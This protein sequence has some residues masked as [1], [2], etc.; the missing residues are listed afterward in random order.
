MNH[1]LYATITVFLT[2]Q[3]TGNDAL[4]QGPKHL[5]FTFVDHFEPTK[6][7]N[8]EVQPW[9]SDYMA[10]ARKHTDADGKHP[11][12][13][14]FLLACPRCLTGAREKHMIPD[15]LRM[16]NTV[17]YGGFGEVDYHLHHGEMDERNRTEEEAEADLHYLNDLTEDIF[18]R[19]GAWVTTDPS[20]RNAIAFI[21]GMW[22]L[23]NSRL[24][25]WTTP[26][27]PYRQFCGVNQELRTLKEDGIYADFTFPAWGPM[28]P[29]VAN[30]KLFYAT[31]DEQP[32]S[33]K[34]PENVEIVEVGKQ[35]NGDLMIVQ[36]PKTNTNIGYLEEVYD[37]PPTLDRMDEW[38]SHNVHVEG[39]DDWVF[40]KVYTHGI[41]AELSNPKTWDYFFGPTMDTFYN[42]IEEKYNDGENWKLHYTSAREMYNII[43]AAEAGVNGDP[44]Q[45]R[46]FEISPYANT[47]I[48]TE[49]EYRLLSYSDSVTFDILDTTAVAEFSLKDFLPTSIVEEYNEVTG[50]WN[51][52]DSLIDS[53]EYGELHFIDSTRSSR[54]RVQ[55][56]PE[57]TTLFL[58]SLGAIGLVRR[59]CRND[60]TLQRP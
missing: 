59:G 51:V 8:S 39:K 47:R 9:I 45:Y 4:A 6:T 33:Y 22:A 16:L 43:K 30:D 32:S 40:V 21:H 55:S 24:N 37:N 49:N 57:P 53:G 28:E 13:S 27:D 56:I 19:H 10:M 23:D 54:Y 12:H 42:E 41:M 36:G 34:N 15:Q 58:L 50:Q 60:C 44:G 46:D 3:C 1:Y 26:D 7:D 52:S 29:D 17:T 38:V 35:S 5:I 25:D 2:V 20:P 14:Y 11:I 18:T 31:D 48:L